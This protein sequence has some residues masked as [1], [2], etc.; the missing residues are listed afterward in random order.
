[1]AITADGK[2]TLNRERLKELRRKLGISQEKLAFQC[3]EQG[4]CVSVASIKRAE[5]SKNILYRTARDISRFY[6]LSVEA[7]I[8]GEDSSTS[9]TEPV[10][11]FAVNRQI[12]LLRCCWPTNDANHLALQQFVSRID[13][14]NEQYWA[15]PVRNFPNDHWFAFGI[16]GIQGTESW[17]AGCFAQK[18]QQRAAEQ[19]LALP[20]C[21]L[22]SVTVSSEQEEASLTNQVHPLL[23][24]PADVF[25]EQVVAGAIVVDAL[26][27]PHVEQHFAT[28]PLLQT[29]MPTLW[30]IQPKPGARQP[31][32]SLAGRRVE[33]VQFRAILDST[34]GFACAHAICLSGVAGIGKSRLLKEFCLLASAGG[35][36][37]QQSN[38]LDFG[39]HSTHQLIPQLTCSLLDLPNDAHAQEN[40][41]IALAEQLE[42]SDQLPVLKTMLGWSLS[43]EQN[44]LLSAMSHRALVERQVELAAMLLAQRARQQPL[45]IAIEDLHWADEPSKQFLLGLLQTI[46]DLPV[47]LVLTYR[48]EADIGAALQHGNASLATTTINLSPLDGGAAKALAD[49]FDDVAPD[50]RQQCIAKSQGNPLF[51]E[52]L[53][54][55]NNQGGNDQ[56]PYSLQTLVLSRLEKLAVKDR[57]AAIAAAVIGQRF[58]VDILNKLLRQPDYDPQPLVDQFLVVRRGENYL[59]NHALIREGIYQ[60]IVTHDRRQL[61]QRCA[62][63]FLDQE[64]S[65]AVKHL[66]WARSEQIESHLIPAIA[67]AADK[68]QYK[69]ALELADIGRRVDYVNINTVN[70]LL[71]QAE[72]LAK[73]GDINRSVVVA[74]DAEKASTAPEQKIQSLLLQANG[75]NTQDDFSAALYAIDAAEKIAI[76]ERLLAQLAKIYHLKGNFY[77]PRGEVKTCINYHEKS[78]TFAKKIDDPDLEAS[79]LGGLGDAAYAQGKMYSAYG[80]L[81]RCLQLCQQHGLQNIE[82]PNLFMLGTVRIYQNQHKQAL[83]DTLRAIQLAQRVGHKRAE[84]VARLTAGWIYLDALQLAQA[85][86]QMT[87]GLALAQEIGAQRFIPFLEESQARLAFYQ[88]DH[89][90]AQSIIAS[91]LKRVEA[92]QAQSFIGPW[93]LGTQALVT[94]DVAQGETALANGQQMLDQGCI[95]HNYFRF[96]VAAMEFGIRHQRPDIIARHRQALQCF[97]ATEPTPWSDF[98]INR[99][100]MLQDTRQG[101]M[102]DGEQRQHLLNQGH[103]AGLITALAALENVAFDIA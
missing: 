64:L 76:R 24:T 65:L 26:L 96:H 47:I 31:T 38:I 23:Q 71:W 73:L 57:D 100:S 10:S 60:S 79:A 84:I 90:Q 93:L 28:M 13:D 67:M 103:E 91:A 21:L 75:L 51:L 15:H 101:K 83:S 16:G 17:R 9:S 62:D 8:A 35:V 98:Y 85:E 5:T 14:L 55:D 78:L 6:Q 41:L 42:I 86:K 40:G 97:T 89:K 53:L 63:L 12:V 46:A 95:G 36:E 43:A 25:A 29:L 72:I 52:Y 82:A 58:S 99:A 18:L 74:I 19:G 87:T 69:T 39:D 68:F 37:V 94:E 70:L 33:L 34:T 77:F 80:Y 61:H 22:A 27:K 56:L 4:L 20:F 88:E 92:L 102:V 54:R 66:H 45:L 48:P 81:R 3:A 32:L 50:Y 2:I 44:R 7:L 1:M 11:G 49:Q 59:F 30:Q